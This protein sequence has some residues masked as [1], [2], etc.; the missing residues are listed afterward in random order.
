MPLPTTAC[1]PGVIL[2]KDEITEQIR[3]WIVT[4]RFAPGE[5]IVDTEIASYFGVSRTPIREVL[6]L[7]EQ[8]KLICTFPGKGTFVAELHPENIYSLYLPMQTLQCLAVRL[9]CD[10]AAPEDIAELEE[11]NRDFLEKAESRDDT[12]GLLKADRK[13]VV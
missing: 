12:L 5:K 10:N 4:L 8:Q 3:E 2:S 11:I 7:L 6:K 9:A 13:S 1:D